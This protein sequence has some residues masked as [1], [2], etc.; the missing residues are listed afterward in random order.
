MKIKVDNWEVNPRSLVDI[1]FNKYYIPELIVHEKFENV[2]KYF[3]WLLIIIGILSSLLIFDKWYFSLSFSVLFTLFT[4]FFEKSI[5]QYSTILVTP[6]PDFDI[7]SDEW[8][9]M[10]YLFPTNPEFPPLLGPTFRSKEYALKFYN[11]LRSWNY[12]EIDDQEDNNIHIS[13]VIEDSSNYSVY[14]YPSPERKNVDELFEASKRHQ[15]YDK[16]GKQQQE[17]IV[18]VTFCRIFPYGYESMVRKF[19]QRYEWGTSFGLSVFLRDESL[20]KV[21]IIEEAEPIKKQHIRHMNRKNVP[22]NSLE[23]THEPKISR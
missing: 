18:M 7:H 22:E 4:L 19:V 16:Q 20:N 1:R 17:L 23:Y 10:A 12:N 6:L 14:L 2:L 8:N 9:G 11:L 3:L 5:I 15:A 21:S 13:F